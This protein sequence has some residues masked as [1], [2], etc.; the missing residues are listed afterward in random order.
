[1]KNG[2]DFE[3]GLI[4]NSKSPHSKVRSPPIHQITVLDGFWKERMESSRRRGV[5]RLLELLEE[6]GVIDNFRRLSR[7]KDVERRGPVFTDSDVYKWMEAAAFLL[8]STKDPGLESVLDGIVDDVV[9]VQ[10]NDGYLNTFFVGERKKDRYSNLDRDHE[11]YCAGH[12]I[13]A[14]VAHY[15]A[16]GKRRL[17]DCAIGFADQLIRVFG[18]GKRNGFSGHPELE[19]AMIELYRTTGNADCLAFAGYLLDQIGFSSRK[20]M[21]GHA[22]RAGYVCCGGTDYF[23]ETGDGPTWTALERLWLDTAERKSYITGGIGSRYVGE[24]FGE[25]YELPNLR[26]YAETC[27]AVSH[28]MW[29]WRMLGVT[30]D[31]KY[32]DMLERVLYNGF[33]SGVSHSGEKYFYINPLE[34]Y[35]TADAE[36]RGHQRKEWYATTCCPTNVVRTMASLP[37]YIYGAGPNEIWV[38]LYQAS[39]LDHR[40]RSGTVTIEQSTDYPWSGDVEIKVGAESPQEFTIFLRIPSWT[41]ICRVSVNGKEKK[42]PTP[43]TYLRLKREWIPGDRIHLTLGMPVRLVDAH[44]RVR[45]NFGCAA[46]CRGPLVYCVESVDN[47]DFP[48]Q[49]LLLPPHPEFDYQFRPDLLGGINIIRFSALVAGHQG[50]LYGSLGERKVDLSEVDVVAIPYYAWANR[51]RSS[52][53]VWLPLAGSLTPSHSK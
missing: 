43:G 23:S 13:Q 11:F 22:V 39:R 14:A 12:L 46:I 51:A 24:A 30:G 2:Q 35:G 52:M 18:P 41:S 5:P 50:N 17:L 37:G 53:T 25:P 34:S 16:T 1:M 28:A 20:S 40:T 10:D 4:D 36:E 19:M 27:A 9:G 3:A 47:P 15:R 42:E 38:N 49:D 7:G 31:P 8:Q 45:E 21:Q 6:H 29:S 48:V 26:A 44:P 33:L 32:G